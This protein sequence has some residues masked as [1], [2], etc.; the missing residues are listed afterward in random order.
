M[1]TRRYKV[2]ALAILLLLAVMEPLTVAADDA[3]RANVGL[4]IGEWGISQS[5]EIDGG[6]YWSASL[7]VF[8]SKWLMTD[9]SYYTDLAPYSFRDHL[10]SV[11]LLFRV[12]KY[13]EDFSVVLGPV[14]LTDLASIARGQSVGLKLVLLNTWKAEH[15]A[16]DDG[17]DM[18]FSILPLSVLYELQSQRP[19]FVFSLF[20]MQFFFD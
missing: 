3:S 14:Y 16:E 7:A 2:P 8:L 10:V 15:S 1:T 13:W 9:F 12:F 17:L 11:D 19:V 4:S 18:T 5:A 20:E 6:Y